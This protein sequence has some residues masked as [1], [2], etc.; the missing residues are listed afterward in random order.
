MGKNNPDT[1]GGRRV[2]INQPIKIYLNP[3]P[4]FPFIRV[5][6]RGGWWRCPNCKTVLKGPG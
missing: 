6:K 2:P 5:T 3:D 1:P 4:A